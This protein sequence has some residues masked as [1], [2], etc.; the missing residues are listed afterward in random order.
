MV[1]KPIDG[2]PACHANGGTI[3]FTVDGPE[4]VEAWHKAGT[5]NGGTAIE[6]PPG[7]LR[8][9][10]MVRGFKRLSV[11]FPPFQASQE[12][13]IRLRQRHNPHCGKAEGRPEHCQRR[14]LLTLISTA[15][16]L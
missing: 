15:S 4:Q 5:A 8:S 16:P 9:F 10:R 6:G 12:F 13:S 7:V 14:H 3:G 1:T 2:Q 11:S